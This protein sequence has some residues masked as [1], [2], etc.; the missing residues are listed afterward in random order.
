M[1]AIDTNS[2]FKVD[3]TRG[4]RNSRVASE[5][6]SR[7]ADERYLTL[8]TLFASVA[9]RAERS[10]TRTVASRDVRVQA[11]Q[12]EADALTVILPGNKAIALDLKDS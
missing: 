3:P 7:P 1:N 2:S 4:A 5:W 12:N 8:D 9:E 6:Y 11:P 10:R